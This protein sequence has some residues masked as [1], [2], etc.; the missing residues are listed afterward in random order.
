MSLE[1]AA[2]RFRVV[3][4]DGRRFIVS[5]PTLGTL[6]LASGLFPNEIS[7]FAHLAITNPAMLQGD[8]AYNVKTLGTLLG[9]TS[10]GRA[11][12]VLETCVRAVGGDHGDV[13][14]ATTLS[15]GL[16]AVLGAAVLSLC[17][18]PRCFAGAGWDKVGKLPVEA[19]ARSQQSDDWVDPA[20]GSF[21][22]AI[23][24]MCERFGWTLRQAMEMPFECVLMVN[25]AVA[26]IDDPEARKRA[27]DAAQ[28]FPVQAFA[29][30]GIGYERVN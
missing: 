16:A 9:D 14:A 6:V 23:V 5:A 8:H 12:E 13:I 26:V 10:D 11:G 27:S 15:P 7:A 29:H 25:D 21:E 18:V 28:E 24:A 3:T 2:G 17:D 20:D 4:H 19:P 1:A 22:R 30:L